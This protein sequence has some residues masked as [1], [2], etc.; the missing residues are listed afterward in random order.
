[1]QHFGTGARTEDEI[2]FHVV[3]GGSRQ[4]LSINAAQ[5]MTPMAKCRAVA[6]FYDVTALH[7][8]L[9]GQQQLLLDEI[10][11]GVKNTMANIQSIALFDA[12]GCYNH[13]PVVQHFS[14][15]CSPSRMLTTFNR[16]N[17]RGAEY[18]GRSWLR[19][20]HLTA[21]PLRSKSSAARF[22]YRRNTRSRFTATLQELCTNAAKYGSLSVPEGRLGIHW[23]VGEGHVELRWIETN[24]PRVEQPTRRGF[25]IV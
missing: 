3:P 2:V 23:R 24:G 22:S 19:S 8:A 9:D 13:R 6:A 16:A 10:N 4:R 15:G 5:F 21:A 7:D 12:L 18:Q 14:K 25:G 1:M 17:W 11:H 20:P